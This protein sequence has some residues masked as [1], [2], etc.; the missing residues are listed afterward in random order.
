[1]EYQSQ[2]KNCQNCKK[3]F[4]IEPDDFSFYE[5]MKVPPPT[6]CSEYRWSDKWDFRDFVMDH[7]F[8]KNFFEQF[9]Y[10]TRLYS[11]K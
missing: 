10:K 4:V 5:K 9:N 11:Y 3:D 7:D 1:M 8:S 6:F 2:T